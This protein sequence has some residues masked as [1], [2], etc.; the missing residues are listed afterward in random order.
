MNRANGTEKAAAAAGANR[1]V[2]ARF[3]GSKGFSGGKMPVT[4]ERLHTVFRRGTSCLD[5]GFVRGAKNPPD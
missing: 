4:Q 2:L 1:T 3:I 5:I